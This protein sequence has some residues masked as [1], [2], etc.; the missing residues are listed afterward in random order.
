MTNSMREMSPLL[1]PLSIA[2]CRYITLVPCILS[3]QSIIR[4]KIAEAAATCSQNNMHLVFVFLQLAED[5]RTSTV[6]MRY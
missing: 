6:Y 4:P 5:M 3:N 2:R 1:K